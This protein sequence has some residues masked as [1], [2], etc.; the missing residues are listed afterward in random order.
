[1]MFNQFVKDA[2]AGIFGQFGFFII[3]SIIPTAIWI[4]LKDK[5]AKGR[6][7]GILGAFVFKLL[8]R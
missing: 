7:F 2:I 1:M 3:V 8:G 6:E 5:N 4:Y